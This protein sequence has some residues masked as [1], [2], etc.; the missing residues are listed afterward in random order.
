MKNDPPVNTRHLSPLD[1]LL[2]LAG[3]ALADATT[4]PAAVRPVPGRAGKPVTEADATMDE[5]ARRHAAG[6]MRVNHVGEVCAQALYEGH[7]LTVGDARLAS[8]F[9]AAA[10]EERDHLAWTRQRLRELQSPPSLLIPVWYLGSLSLG[11]LAGLAG[12][13][14]ALGF[15][16]ETERQV[17]AHLQSHL[18]RLPESDTRSRAIVEQMKEDEAR[19]GDEARQRGG[20]TIPRPIVALMRFTSRIMTGVAYRI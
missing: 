15:M 7:A 10:D 16:A 14:W 6:L 11:S 13:R 5:G 1:R 8:F 9:M 12:A 18:E 4:L 17:E 2:S 3:R 19:H 20:A